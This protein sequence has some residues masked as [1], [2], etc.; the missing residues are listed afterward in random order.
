MATGYYDF[1][2]QTTGAA[3]TGWLFSS[4]VPGTVTATVE[5]DGAAPTGKVMRLSSGGQA[6]VTAVWDALGALEDVEVAVTWRQNS[7]N[8][9]QYRDGFQAI[10]RAFYNNSANIACYQAS[11]GDSGTNYQSV[12]NATNIVSGSTQRAGANLYVFTNVTAIE[13][14]RYKVRTVSGSEVE[15]KGWFWHDAQT[16]KLTTDTPDVTWTDTTILRAAG[17]I[18]AAVHLS[19]TGTTDLLWIGYGTNGDAAPLTIGGGGGPTQRNRALLSLLGV[20]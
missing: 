17:R 7:I 19:F 4:N 13:N 9:A 11:S 8:Q 18:G 2:A 10:S 20:V 15:H 1:G 12:G 16:A 5:A 3:P 6:R 14:L